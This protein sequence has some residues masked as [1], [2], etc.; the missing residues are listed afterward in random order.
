VVV[1]SCKSWQK[2][3]AVQTKITELEQDKVVSGR[4]AWRAFRELMIPKWSEA[5][6]AAIKAATGC[7][8]FTYIT[9]VT[10]I[11]GDR[12]LWE[13][14]PRFQTALQ[15]NPV[16]LLDLTD[17]LRELLPTLNTTPS[18]SQF[19]RTLQLL[20]AANCSFSL[21]PATKNPAS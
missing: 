21:G 15:G 9:A 14:Y 1:V 3:F 6:L 17:M 18:N 10:V 11:K 13:S 7:A 2:G 8:Q 5:F 4:K 19:G 16:R 20:K 12:S